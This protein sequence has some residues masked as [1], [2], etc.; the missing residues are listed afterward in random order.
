[1]KLSL[2]ANRLLIVN[3]KKERAALF[4]AKIKMIENIFDIGM[5]HF[6]GHFTRV[7]ATGRWRPA[8]VARTPDAS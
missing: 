5:I 4:P 3:T 1:V 6:T 8:T 7:L 2:L